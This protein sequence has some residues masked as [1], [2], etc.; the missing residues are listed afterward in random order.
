MHSLF[1]LKEKKKPLG[2]EVKGVPYSLLNPQS[3]LYHLLLFVFNE[4]LILVNN[5]KLK[6]RDHFKSKSSEK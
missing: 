2:L 4:Q 1:I 5:S 6:A 3:S